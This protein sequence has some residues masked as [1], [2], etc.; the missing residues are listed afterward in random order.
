MSIVS[1]NNY[2]EKNPDKVLGQASKTNKEGKAYTDRFGKH[3]TRYEGTIDVLDNIIVPVINI[4]PGHAIPETNIDQS[5]TV[6]EDDN[7]ILDAN[8]QAESDIAKIVSKQRKKKEEDPEKF[9]HPD[10]IPAINVLN[11]RE[12][13]NKG[14]TD[15][16]IKAYIWY[17]RNQNIKME[18][19]WRD[20][21]DS[22]KLSGEQEAKLIEQW[23]R[24]GCVFFYKGSLVYSAFYLEGDIYDKKADIDNESTKKAIIKE[25]GEEIYNNQYKLVT[26]AYEEVL[27]DKLR[28]GN[29]QTDKTQESDELII[30]IVPTAEFSR[31]T[32]ITEL[33]DRKPFTGYTSEILDDGYKIPSF[34]NLKYGDDVFEK[35]NLLDAFFYWLSKYKSSVYYK[36]DTSWE[37]ILKFY[38]GKGSRSKDHSITEGNAIKARAKSEGKR[39]FLVFL[40]TQLTPEDK[41]RVEFEYNRKYNNYF[42][43]DYDKIPIAFTTAKYYPGNEDMEIRYEKREAVAFAQAEGSGIL[44]YDVGVGKT[45]SDI[46][47]MEQALESGQAKRCLMVVPNQTY[48]QWMSET[49]GI[50]PHR[51]INDLYNLSNDYL[52]PLRNEKDGFAKLPPG[53]ISII[54]KEGMSRLGIS[55]DLSY[56][57]ADRLFDMLAQDSLFFSNKGL[58]KTK[59]EENAIVA[60][61]DK[62]KGYLASGNKGTSVD[63]NEIGIDWIGFDEAHAYK[64]VFT[65]VKSTD[66]SEA[67]YEIGS[68]GKPT[69]IAIKAFILAQYIQNENNDRNTILLTATPVTNSPLEV[70]TML[71][72]VGYEKLKKGIS[73]DESNPNLSN[74][75]KF[76]DHFVKEETEIVI[77]A[78]LQAERRPV[79]KGWR[80]LKV[81]QKILF[82][83]I[84][85]K[86]SD[87]KSKHGQKIELIRPN[88]YLLP[89]RGRYVEGKFIPVALEDMVDLTLQMSP[90]QE[91]LTAFIKEY[92]TGVYGYSGLKANIKSAVPEEM[93]RKEDDTLLLKE[94]QISKADADD[95]KVDEADL[96]DDEKRGVSLLRSVNLARSVGISPYLL[97]MESDVDID[98]KTEN[99]RLM[100]I[101]KDPTYK[102]YVET[103][104]KLFVIVKMAKMIKDYFEQEN[105]PVPGQVIYLDRGKEYLPLIKEYLIKEMGFKKHEVEIISSMG[106]SDK[107]VKKKRDIQNAF[108]GVREIEGTGKKAIIPDSERIKIIIGTSSIREGMNLQMH[109]LVLYDAFIG[110]NPTDRIQIEGRIW[111]Q[112]NKFFNVFIISPLLQNSM[113]T[114]MLQKLEEKTERINTLWDKDGKTNVLGTEEYNPEELKYQLITDPGVIADMELDEEGSE[115]E[116]DKAFIEGEIRVA[117]TVITSYNTISEYEIKLRK[118]VDFW[119]P[120]R[121]VV[122]KEPKEVWQMTLQEYGFYYD[123]VKNIAPGR[124][125]KILGKKTEIEI[126]QVSRMN[127][128][129]IKIGNKKYKD[130]GIIAIADAIFGDIKTDRTNLSDEISKAIKE[131]KYQKAVNDK[132]MSYEKAVNIITRYDNEIPNDL[133]KPTVK[134]RELSTI[135]SNMDKIVA[136]QTDADGN[137]IKEHD[138]IE[139]VGLEYGYGGY[140]VVAPRWLSLLKIATATVKRKGEDKPVFK[141]PQAVKNYITTLNERLEDFKNKLESLKSGDARV[142]KTKEVIAK[143]ER[144]YKKPKSLDQIVEKFKSFDDKFLELRSVKDAS[145]KPIEDVLKNIPPMKGGKPAIDHES[146]KLL[147]E[148]VRRLP[149]TAQMHQDSEGNYTPERLE[150]H[151]K[152]KEKF[153][154]NAVCVKDNQ[155]PVAII[156]AGIPGS[157]KTTFMSKYAPYMTSDK[158]L[159]IDADAI[160]AEF[161]EY[162]GWN[163]EQT[164]KE[165]SGIVRDI[166]KKLGSPCKTDILYDG[167]MNKIKEYMDLVTQLKKLNY[168]IYVIFMDVPGDIAIE[169]VLKRYQETKRYVPMSVMNHSIQVGISIFDKIKTMV[170]GYLV[171]DGITSEIISKHGEEIPKDRFYFDDKAFA[172][173]MEITD[174]ARTMKELIFTL[175]WIDYKAEGGKIENSSS[176]N[177]KED[178][179]SNAFYKLNSDNKVELHFESAQTYK[180]LPEEIKTNIKRGFVWGRQRKAWVSRSKGGHIPYSMQSY[181]IAYKGADDLSSFEDIEERKVTRL[182]NK[183][184]RYSEYS[185]NA[186]KRA[187]GMQSEFNKLRKDWSWITQ[188]NVNTS[189]GR[190]FSR[191]R[192]KV[193]ARYEKGMQEHMKSDSMAEYANDLSIRATQ[194]ELKNEYYLDNRL[195]ENMKIVKN[196][197][198]FEEYYNDKIKDKENLDDKSL[199][200]LDGQMNRYKLAFDKFEYYSHYKDLLVETKKE[201][202]SYFDEAEAKKTIKKEFKEF[203]QKHYGI[204]LL[205]MSIAYS[206]RQGPTYFY[207]TD[208]D[209]PEELHSGWAANNA[210]QQNIRFLINFMHKKETKKSEEPKAEVKKEIV[211]KPSDFFY[212]NTSKELL[213]YLHSGNRLK[214][215]DYYEKPFEVKYQKGKSGVVEGLAFYKIDGK[216]P[217]KTM[218]MKENEILDYISE[219]IDSPDNRESFTKISKKFKENLTSKK[220]PWQM[221]RDEFFQSLQKDKIISYRNREVSDLYHD[222]SILKNIFSDEIEKD[223]TGSG[224]RKITDSINEAL[225]SNTLKKEIS[226]KASFLYAKKK[227]IELYKKALKEK[228]S[229]PKEV[230][231]DYPE[232]EAKSEEATT[233]SNSIIEFKIG[234]NYYHMWAGD[235]DLITKYKVLQR[236]EKT[237]TLEQWDDKKKVVKKIK[238]YEGVEQVHPTG[239][240]SMAPILKAEKL[241]KDLETKSAKEP[242]SQQPEAKSQKPDIDKDYK[243][244]IGDEVSFITT[245]RK[246][247]TGSVHTFG[248]IGWYEVKT[249]KSLYKVKEE[250]LTP[251][252][253]S[254]RKTV[255]TIGAQLTRFHGSSKSE[256]YKV[257]FNDKT[258]IKVQSAYDNNDA[259]AIA[260]EKYIADEKDKLK[261]SKSLEKTKFLMKQKANELNFNDWY[262]WL[263]T[264]SPESELF[265]SIDSLEVKENTK[266]KYKDL[267]NEKKPESKGSHKTKGLKLIK[268]ARELR[269]KIKSGSDDKTLR[270]H[271]LKNIK[272]K[273]EWRKEE[274]N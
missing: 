28:I 219:F 126:L 240:Y 22:D 264:D 248:H 128:Y 141:S 100:Y 85:F 135:L 31:N 209:L 140:N 174:I 243:Y 41:Q 252:I 274:L 166:L 244:Q 87:T 207:R 193:T 119:R 44:A 93:L 123:Q 263:I 42:S 223:Y 39:L 145:K 161:P 149:Q 92:A 247:I 8:K 139:G 205:K 177:N 242:K 150:F 77:N 68:G 250:D 158:L 89:Y 203:L 218:A 120:Q 90:I 241:V 265:H 202:G 11:D 190:S 212:K 124:N 71:S 47:I 14:L 270:M 4:A 208:K 165:A 131:K 106:S 143:Q 102:E 9:E 195:K 98:P 271:L 175:G 189:G 257:V 153:A 187:E 142:E 249:G 138:F 180:D 29:P 154:E 199:I 101:F 224:I 6:N 237:V 214:L 24:D 59:K 192:D 94:I 64:K 185:E 109:S 113:D 27:K 160:R 132:K 72:F 37:K 260:I 226:D 156:T 232:L 136:S 262:N 152:I 151:N 129:D 69:T 168:K 52:N 159:M 111:R 125:L 70:Y 97:K 238:V 204:K 33:V 194:T 43:I 83:L 21:F 36:K 234:E 267:R 66:K 2:F 261:Y 95:I 181:K 213:K 65:S 201:E 67:K 1:N 115:Y 96:K 197:P 256:F 32:Y 81:L 10:L 104:S 239:T 121:T 217:Y 38:V 103:S 198:E 50:L 254:A 266:E 225:L 245:G 184:E 45:W 157:G 99:G 221:T 16:D 79:F 146:I 107:A 60:T 91:M 163:A 148:T 137:P 63:I 227:I 183:A 19:V 130:Q 196:F 127:H 176:D 54:T 105:N 48:S 88:K 80:N 269:N 76:F 233:K 171:V 173:T 73:F 210:A 30:D 268:E 46:M 162:K 216:R 170:D 56:K 246:V 55:D 61:Q 147:E 253:I 230:L 15:N 215:V 258:I 51:I 18:G 40:Q 110:W 57:I 62:I 116:E 75:V 164:N 133:I 206:G 17:Q 49:K 191:Q 112:K 222:N 86:N 74:V 231:N 134:P 117:E 3:I 211:L 122:D 35:L 7:R 12:N 251:K 84:S 188:P 20:F 259:K 235:Y 182:E 82:K 155:Q 23:L 272:E 255:E 236:T 179:F 118:I 25:Y 169:R 144:L 114:F 228:R 220:E 5:K 13:Y 34:G 167:T 178:I 78:A 200:Y 273:R 53:S 172:R 58:D 108:N 186:K 229:I 26:E